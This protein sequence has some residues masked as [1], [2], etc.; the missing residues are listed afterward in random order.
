MST[1]VSSNLPCTENGVKL[2][3]SNSSYRSVLQAD[4]YDGCFLGITPA[5]AVLTNIE[6]EHVDIF[7]DMVSVFFRTLERS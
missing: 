7:P 5:L 2:G 1:I 6:W 4:E 3:V